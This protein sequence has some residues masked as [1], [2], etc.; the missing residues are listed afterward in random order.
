MSYARPNR[1][2]VGGKRVQQWIDRQEERGQEHPDVT[3]F[4]ARQLAQERGL[5]ANVVN[6]YNDSKYPTGKYGAMG[7]FGGSFGGLAGRVADKELEEK[8]GRDTKA[9]IAGMQGA[10]LRKGD[11]YMG[12]TAIETPATS[13]NTPWEGHSSTPASTRYDLTV[14]PRWMVK[15]K[16][17]SGSPAAA[18]AQQTAPASTEPNVDLTKAREAYDRAT[19]YQSQGGETRGGSGLDL[20]ASGSSLYQNLF[21]AGNAGVSD[22]ENRFIPALDARANLTAQEIRY[23]AGSAIDALPDNLQLPTYD[24]MFPKAAGKKQGLYK[25]L[26]NRLA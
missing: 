10:R 17:Q 21:D 9:D 22:Y 16:T 6:K 2:V 4:L 12:A 11:V 26:E 19:Q 24:K 23:E 15:Q 25:W 14:L 5:S 1:P 3:K 20:T 7:A 18:P 13:V 8:Y